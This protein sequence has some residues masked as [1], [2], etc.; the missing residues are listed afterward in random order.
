MLTTA[1]RVTIHL[2][3]CL[4]LGVA[5]HLRCPNCGASLKLSASATESADEARPRPNYPYSFGRNRVTTPHEYEGS[6]DAGRQCILCWE[7]DDHPIH[8]KRPKREIRFEEGFQV[9]TPDWIERQRQ[10][11]DFRESNETFR[12]QCDKEP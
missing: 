3:I 8:A 6:V 2:L 9:G 7:L 11:R 1:N 5:G 10:L 4:A 12:V